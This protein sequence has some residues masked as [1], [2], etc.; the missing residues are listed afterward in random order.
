MF[1][2]KDLKQHLHHKNDNEDIYDYEKSEI[3][4]YHKGFLYVALGQHDYMSFHHDLMFIKQFWSQQDH[5]V[6]FK[7]FFVV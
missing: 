1:F 2:T 6:Y 7:G 3:L 4:I 5:R